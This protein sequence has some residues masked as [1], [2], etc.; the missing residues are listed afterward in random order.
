M[1]AGGHGSDTA[2]T[3]V[4]LPL[5]RPR[6]RRRSTNDRPDGLGLAYRHSALA[7][8]DV[9]VS[10]TY[11]LE[12]G[13]VERGRAVIDEIVR[14]RRANQPGGS[15]AGSVFTNPPGDSAGRL[16]E[17]CGLKGF[18]LGTR[19]GVG[20][21]RQLLPGRPRRLGRRRAPAH[22][23]RAGRGG[24][25]D[26]RRAGAPRCA[27]SGSTTGR[28]PGDPPGRPGGRARRRPAPRRRARWGAG[29]APPADR[30][31]HPPAP[32]VGGPQPRPAS[33][34]AAPRRPRSGRR[35]GGRRWPSSTPR[36]SA[37][38]PSP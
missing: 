23:P 13:P 22:R 17:A 27:W 25:G 29:P 21:A 38:G 30:P 31:P 32:P 6:A 14:W 2:A 4:E 20:Q 12:P 7:A 37:P 28:R 1:N 24:G 16:I 5:R 35:G 36:C 3:L 9:V 8:T 19:R 33:P 18:R 11:E 10:G 26:R 15:N 34:A